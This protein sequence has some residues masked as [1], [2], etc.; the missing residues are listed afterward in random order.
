MRHLDLW[1]VVADF[2]HPMVSEERKSSQVLQSRA[3][4]AGKYVLVMSARW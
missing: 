2:H 1:I 3:T 4:S